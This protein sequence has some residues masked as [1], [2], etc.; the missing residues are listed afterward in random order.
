MK[1]MKTTLSIEITSADK[2][3]GILPEEGQTEEDFKGEDAKALDGF[4]KE[5]AKDFHK[6]IVD[7]LKGYFADEF[8]EDLLDS[9]D[10]YYVEGWDTL[11]DYGTKIKLSVKKN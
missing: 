8:E 1:N 2:V 11:K 10:E 5:F 6:A 9:L 7:Y 3:T 4:R